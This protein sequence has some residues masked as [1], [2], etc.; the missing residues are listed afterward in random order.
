MG[1]AVLL[2]GGGE[3]RYAILHAIALAKRIGEAIHGIRQ[4]PPRPSVKP[5]PEV[6]NLGQTLLLQLAGSAGVEVRCHV[7][8]GNDQN[9]LRVLLREQ[10]IFCLIIGASDETEGRR[11]EKR[12]QALRRSIASDRHW[13]IGPFWAMVTGPWSEEAMAAAL[14]DLADGY[15]EIVEKRGRTP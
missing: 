9:D 13:S 14:D 15:R 10:R 11:A 4:E 12:M 5:D 7:L 8:A 1:I 2:G 6:S 3:D